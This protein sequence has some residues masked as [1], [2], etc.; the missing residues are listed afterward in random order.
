MLEVLKVVGGLGPGAGIGESCDGDRIE[1]LCS[2]MKKGSGEH[3][4]GS[5]LFEAPL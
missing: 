4:P 1:E 2:S 3:A 5:F